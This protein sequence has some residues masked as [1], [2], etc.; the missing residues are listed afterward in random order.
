[1]QSAPRR[2]ERTPAP[3]RPTSPGWI[4]VIV[5]GLLAAVGVVI[6]V[7]LVGAYIAL[8]RDLVG[9]QQLEAVPPHEESIV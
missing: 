4:A 1:L 7:G 8:S 3:A 2:V 9:P 5:F 6:A